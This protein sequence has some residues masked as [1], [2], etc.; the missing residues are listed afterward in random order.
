MTLMRMRPSTDIISMAMSIDI[1]EFWKDSIKASVLLRASAMHT[2]VIDMTLMRMRPSTDIISMAMSID[3]LE[4]WKDSIKASVLLRA[5]AMHTCVI[6]MVS[7][8]TFIVV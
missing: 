7:F 2:C 5:S 1:L 6:D 8:L 3:I 4:F